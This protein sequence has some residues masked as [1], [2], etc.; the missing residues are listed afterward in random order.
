[1]QAS[2]ALF[3][4]QVVALIAMGRLMSEIMNRLGQPAV[5]GQLIAGMLLGPSVLGSLWPAGQHL[6]F[7]SSATQQAMLQGVAHLGVLLILL[8][9]GMETDLSLVRRSGRASLSVS[10]AGIALPFVCGVVLA[11]HLPDAL[12]PDPG[13]RLVTALFLGTA[14]SISSVKIVALLIRDLGFLRR[15]VGQ[16]ILASAVID[17]TIGWILMSLVF[18]IAL[19][20]GV[21]L[22]SLARS[23]L[24][25]L[26]FLGLSFTVGR[27][28]VFRLIRWS[29]DRF[30]SELPVIAM[31]LVITGA[32]ALL[33][34]AIGVHT[35]LGAFV[36]GI[37]IGQSPILTRHIEEALRGLIVALFMPVFFGLAGLTA[38]LR[39]LAQPDMLLLTLGVIAVASIG[40]FSGALVGGRI[41][42]LDFPQSLAVGAGMNARGSTEVIIATFG[43]SMGALSRDLFTAIVTMAVITTLAMPP[44]LRWAVRRLKMTPE[45][46]RR[47]ER[48][49]I[50]SRSFVAGI[51]RLL[52]TV[53]ASRSGE[54]ASHLVGLLAGVRG[55][56]ATA[57]HLD[58][59]MTRGPGPKAPEAKRT[60]EVLTR[61]AEAGSDA[62]PAGPSDASAANVDLRVASPALDEQR[63]AEEARKGYGLLFIGREPVSDG[64]TIHEQITRSAMSF[65]GSFAIVA[66]RGAHER[67]LLDAPLRILVPVTGT[68]SSRQGAE[69]AI[70]LGRGSHGEL[71]VLYVAA[72]STRA[73]RRSTSLW[74][75]AAPRDEVGEAVLRDMEG[76]GRLYHVPVRGLMVNHRDTAEA[77]LDAL[78]DGA[79]NLLVSGVN[80][81]S[82]RQLYFGEVPARLLERAPC[83]LLFLS[84]EPA[85]ATGESRG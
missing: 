55:I 47:L 35:V 58:E 72:P 4:A 5:M 33:T 67:G 77:I 60:E 50:E 8:L 22:P 14:M 29:N 75:S 40:K 11:W 63:I 53:D 36:A 44:M 80:P 84:R 74:R 46:Q 12:I 9:T 73:A 69:L 20:G 81:R 2:E 26:A 17:D 70:A 39:S 6:L 19:H 3:I 28:L 1:M 23:V 45:E 7:P 85:P 62:G 43:L 78:D 18:G 76:L 49:E 64:P 25:T 56:P 24:G 51:E 34:D 48:E 38:D 83:S 21:D 27:R 16:V 79:F 68:L 31:I 57:L 41:G 13:K 59:G 32:M 54:L 37:L 10:L 15:T 30:Q 61:A 42:G 82:A 52:V 65:G 71:T 66:A